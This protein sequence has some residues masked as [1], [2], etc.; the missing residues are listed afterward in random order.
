MTFQSETDSE[1]LANLV[2]FLYETEL[3]H[4]S[5][6]GE[7]LLRALRT[8]LA[9]VEGTYGIAIVCL[10]LPDVIIGAR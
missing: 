4:Q 10:D 3:Q 6:P 9:E 8:S 1:V 7:A 5:A 2:A